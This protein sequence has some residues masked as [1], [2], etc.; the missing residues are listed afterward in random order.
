M[1][2]HWPGGTNANKKGKGQKPKKD[3]SGKKKAEKKAKGKENAP[4]SANV[5][6]VLDMAKLSIQT[7]QSIG[8]SCYE[9]S[10]KVEWCLD[11]GCTDHITPNK[12]DFILYWGLGQASK[13]EITN[14]K[15]L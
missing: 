3:S 5:L 6:N 2:N 15:Y 8:F 9:T 10:E 14:G 7:A 11:S 1:Q 13:A 12:S 4:T